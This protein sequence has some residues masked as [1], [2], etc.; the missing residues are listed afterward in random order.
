MH[1][2]EIEAHHPQSDWG[3]RAAAMRAAAIPVSEILH[4]FNYKPHWTK[5]LAQ[6]A[7]QVMRGESPLSPGERELIAAF[8]SRR[9]NCVF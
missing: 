8:T 6:F 1:L 7:Q 2:H 4:L 5:H 3:E 9:R